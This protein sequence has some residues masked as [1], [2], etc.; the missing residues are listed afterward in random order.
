MA[1]AASSPSANSAAS[2]SFQ[3]VS[4]GCEDKDRDVRFFGFLCIF[5]SD[6]LL[7][8]WCFTLGSSRGTAFC[9]SDYRFFKYNS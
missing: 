3:L 5:L 2:F 9:L 7:K 6:T 1:A 4:S 8:M